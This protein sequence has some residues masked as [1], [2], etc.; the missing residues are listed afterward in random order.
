MVFLDTI[1]PHK[2]IFYTYCPTEKEIISCG[3]PKESPGLA[4]LKD[5]HN[6]FMMAIHKAKFYEHG[7]VKIMEIVGSLTHYNAKT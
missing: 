1:S 7:D 3:Y 6:N 5:A 2:I 4:I